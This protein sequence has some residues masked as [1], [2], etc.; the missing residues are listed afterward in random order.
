MIAYVTITM[1]PAM[2]AKI[3]KRPPN[4]TLMASDGS[5][6]AERGLRRGHIRLAR[7]PRYLINAVLATEDRR[8]R[9]HYG[10]DPV[11]LARAMI[12]NVR[13]RAVVEGG[14]TITQ[15]LAKNVFLTP[16]RTIT[17]KLQ[18]AVLA[19]WLETQ[20]SK[21]EILELYLNRV[22]FGAGT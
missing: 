19:V 15:Q 6:I 5:V 4:V 18:E 1:P 8:F 21:D 14:S 12:K 10:V 11:G 13:A 17:R 9:S 7:M 20:L 2:M 22:Y 16:E 3:K